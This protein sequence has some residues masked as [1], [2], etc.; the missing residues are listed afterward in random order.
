MGKIH[1]RRPPQRL[2]N[3]VQSYTFGRYRARC[4]FAI[5]RDGGGRTVRPSSG[6]IPLGLQ[7]HSSG[8]RVRET[9]SGPV[10]RIPYRHFAALAPR[11]L[12]EGSMIKKVS[13][14]Y[15]VLSEKGKNLGGPYK[16]KKEAEKRLK[17]VE[18]FKHSK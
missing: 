1:S 16:T 15:K 10:K 6:A 8:F 4:G 11:F 14:G 18:Y 3:R 13:G 9:V 5:S 17:Q 2:E 12:T 7:A